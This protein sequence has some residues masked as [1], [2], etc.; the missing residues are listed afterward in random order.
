MTAPAKGEVTEKPQGQT[1]SQATHRA[2]CRS[3]EA[4][5]TYHFHALD[6]RFGVLAIIPKLCNHCL[7]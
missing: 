1:V 4:P 3:V 7:N 5:Q 2:I 6:L